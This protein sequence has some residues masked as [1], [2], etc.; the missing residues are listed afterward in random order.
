M[1][2][3]DRVERGKE[4]VRERERDRE[5]GRAEGN[6]GRREMLVSK[7]TKGNFKTSE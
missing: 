1:R 3:K 6:V 2:E 4:A 5:K 7:N